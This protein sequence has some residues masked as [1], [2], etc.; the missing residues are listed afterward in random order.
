MIRKIKLKNKKAGL[1]SEN[2]VKLV[3]ALISISLLVWFLISL[4]Y[5]SSDLKLAKN[6]LID[7]KR[8]IKNQIQDFWNSDEKERTITIIGKVPSYWKIR[9]F[10]QGLLCACPSP[11][12]GKGSDIILPQIGEDLSEKEECSKKGVCTSLSLQSEGGIVGLSEIT[13]IHLIKK[14]NLLAIGPPEQNGKFN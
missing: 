14:N 3:I 1:L 7:S 12:P 2:V 6:I 8:S 10:E 5:S 11:P 4:Y 13:K 9:L